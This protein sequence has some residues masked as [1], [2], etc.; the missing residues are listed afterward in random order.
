[1]DQPARSPTESKERAVSSEPCS[2]RPNPFD[3]DDGAS[4]R[5]RR[6]TSLNGVSPSRSAETPKSSHDTPLDSPDADLQVESAERDASMTMDSAS[7]EPQTPERQ[8]ELVQPVSESKPTKITLNLKNRR[9]EADFIPSSPMSLNDVDAE[10]TG[11]RENGVRA[12][13]EDSEPD[14]LHTTPDLLDA[15][16]STLD[17]DNPPIE[18]VDDDGSQDGEPQ[19]IILQ[20]PEDTDPVASFPYRTGDPIAESLS[21]LCQQHMPNSK[22]VI[23]DMDNRGILTNCDPD[24]NALTMVRNW[25][26]EYLKW[27]HHRDLGTLHQNFAQYHDFWQVLPLQIMQYSSPHR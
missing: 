12:S 5:K 26:E 11:A 6:R 4:A 24:T 16:S 20:D 1:M 13:V 23:I 10:L 14:V 9:Q 27:A 18:I 25:I 21:K 22:L 7:S 2:T 3:D 17:I 8:Q 19:V 15:D